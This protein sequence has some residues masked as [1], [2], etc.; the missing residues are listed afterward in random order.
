[1]PRVLRIINRFNLGGPTYN[2]SY[3]SK[4]LAP[5]FETLLV[6][7]MKDES[8]KNSE[9]IVRNLGLNPI[10][11]PEMHRSINFCD[12]RKA[13]KKI[14]QIITDFKP[15]IVHTHAAKAGALGRFAAYN[16]KVPVIIH[17]F[18]GHV[19]DAYFNG[20]KSKV[21]Q[22]IEKYLAYK[23]TKIIAISE[24]QKEDL[25]YKYKICPAHKIEIIPLGFDL[26]R[27]QENQSEKRKAFRE[28]FN[29][30][31]NEIAIGITG[32]IVPIKNHELFLQAISYIKYNSSRK[33]RA[34]I[35][36]DGEDRKKVE[37]AANAL[38]VDYV[39]Y[40]KENKKATLTFT[41]W[42]NDI[43][44]INAG[45]DIVALTS[46]NEGTPVSLIE[47]QAS[48]KAIVST[49]VGGIQNIVLPNQTA[50][51]SDVRDID[52]FCKN[53]LE[54]VENDEKR[55]SFSEK[56]WEFVRE[57]YHYT[58]LVNDMKNFYYSLLNK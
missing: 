18:H 28:E 45:L 31:D 51:L 57:K 27:F 21:Y 16:L 29:V 10:T 17:T 23:S 20:A 4:Y 42:R 33:I 7:G 3:L 32:R 1:M 55:N 15:D 49:N 58:R 6:G 50:L 34:F 40:T 43:D 35:I 38:A 14:K 2:A 30:S 54:L 12:D 24:N 37:Y 5:E 53:L 25:A 47:A 19:F 9:F 8:E 22:T 44:Y 48:N 26:T 36:G 56:G 39:D 41:S 52:K 13:Y 11:I 46:L